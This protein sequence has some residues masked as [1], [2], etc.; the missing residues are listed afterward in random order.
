[1]IQTTTAQ[2]QETLE[3]ILDLQAR[4]YKDNL[5]PEEAAEQGFLTARYSLSDLETM[6][7]PYRHVV[8]MDGGGR[9]AG[10]AL[11]ML[12]EF[13]R[14]FPLLVSMFERINRLTFGGRRLAETSYFVMGQVCV[15][16]KYRGNKDLQVFDRLYEG[17]KAQMSGDFDLVVT[18]VSSRNP[19]S[20]KAHARVGFQ[21]A[22]RYLDEKDA[23]EI[24]VW[25]WRPAEDRSERVRL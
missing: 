19:R 15:E 2:S 8:A 12:K 22:D 13:G 21:P 6:R 16:K 3:Q 18:E 24:I 4:N 23:W 5:S 1:M 17:L 11:V 10:Y 25:D 9:L 20:S 7:G 14:D